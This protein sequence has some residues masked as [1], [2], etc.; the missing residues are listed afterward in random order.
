M[1][2]AIYLISVLLLSVA[3]SLDVLATHR[4]IVVGAFVEGNRVMDWLYKTN[5]PSLRQLWAYNIGTTVLIVTPSFVGL[6]FNNV[7]LTIGGFGAILGNAI[8]HYQSYRK[9]LAYLH[10]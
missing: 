4:G 2:L 3:T 10:K 1:F 8:H 7:V 9:C 5:K 6:D